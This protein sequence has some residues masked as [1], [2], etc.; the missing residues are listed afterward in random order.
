MLLISWREFRE[1]HERGRL[2]NVLYSKM[3][4]SLWKINTG[5]LSFLF[6]FSLLEIVV[7][8]AGVH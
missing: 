2:Q 6:F 1:D 4:R 5:F 7:V 3:R 8:E